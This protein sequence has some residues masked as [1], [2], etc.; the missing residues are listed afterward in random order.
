MLWL[1]ALH[2]YRF[3]S[4]CHLSTYKKLEEA[5]Y[6]RY[7]AEQLIFKEYRNT[8]E[9]A[10]KEEKISLISQSRKNELYNYVYTKLNSKNMIK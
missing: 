1:L 4:R 8:N 6:V 5:V 7:I 10:K 9:D 3:Q 2:L